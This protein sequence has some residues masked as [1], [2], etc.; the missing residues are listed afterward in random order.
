MDIPATISAV[1][2][3][4]GF[5][6][7]LNAIDVQADKAELKLKIAEISSALADAKMG[8]IDAVEIVREKDKA[9]AEAK[10]ALKF[11]AENLINFDGMFYD[12]RDGKP[13]GD[14]YCTVCIETGS[15]YKLVN[16]VSAAGHPFKCPKCKSN[17]GMARAFTKV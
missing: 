10:A 7:E 13:V 15:T 8:L 11:R 14:P 4:L 12:Q 6:R 3:A 2:T 17:Y 5:V 1:T 9:I 16:D